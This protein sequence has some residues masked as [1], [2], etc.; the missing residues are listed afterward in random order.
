MRRTDFFLTIVGGRM[1]FTIPEMTVILCA[2]VYLFG[3]AVRGSLLSVVVVVLAGGVSFAG[4]GLL[5]A[6][7]TDRIETV[8]GLINLI[9][10]PMWLFS[11]IFFSY[12]R[13]PQSLHPFIKALPLTQLIDALRAV[14]LEGATVWSQWFALLYLLT[15]GVV[16]FCLALRWFRWF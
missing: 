3:I 2:G 10:L 4:I 9:M 7:R 11:G 14:I 1:M 13:F 5:V 12:E 8:S 16:C 6:S 15:V